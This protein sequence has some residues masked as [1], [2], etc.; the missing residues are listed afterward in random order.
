MKVSHVKIFIFAGI[1]LILYSCKYNKKE[2]VKEEA[3]SVIDVSL[4][5]RQENIK[6]STFID[7][8][9]ILSLNLPSNVVIGRAT[10]VFFY[11]S[12]IFI[13]DRLQ[14]KIFHFNM[15]G[16]F[17]G[18]LYR[19]GNGQGE[20]H[21]IHS[22]M[23]KDDILY[24][25]DKMG[26]NILLYDLSFDFIQSIHCKQWVENLTILADGSFLCF[27]PNFIYNAPNGIW[28]MDRDGKVMKIWHKYNEKF[29]Y[30]SSEWNPFYVSSS[31]EI[32]IR[33]PIRNT[34]YRFN[35]TNINSVMKWN[36]KEKTTLDFLGIESCLSVKEEFWICPIF[37]D[38]DEWVFGIWGEYNGNTSEL[39]SLYSKRENKMFV[40]SSLKVDVGCL[41][42]MGNPVS[43]NIPNAMVAIVDEEVIMNS[44]SFKLG[45]TKILPENKILLLI[46]HF[47]SSRR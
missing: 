26:Q 2:E 44:R 45:Q 20:Y 32:G 13:L 14:Q 12:H 42:Y 21:G 25:F 37:I 7:S 17:L 1:L 34:F 18:E 6:M 29:P 22:C 15:D 27:T 4:Q 24:V 46:Y 31:N 19:R 28:Q 16:T 38:A 3:T 40:S 5:D 8:V 43:S 33:C 39:F 47:L 23:V 30:V 36:V 9:Q 10:R 41:S 35:D 11:N